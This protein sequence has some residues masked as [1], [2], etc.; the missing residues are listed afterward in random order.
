MAEF[1]PYKVLD[2]T[3]RATQADIK[4]AYRRLAKQYHPDLN[5]DDSSHLHERF[6]QVTRAYRVLGDP[7]LKLRFDR[8][9]LEGPALDAALRADPVE[10]AAA[11]APRPAAAPE[12]PDAAAP[13]RPSYKPQVVKPPREEAPPAPQEKPKAAE[14]RPSE[15]SAATPASAPAPTPTSAAAPRPR[16]A[17]L[18]MPLSFID[19]ARGT[20]RR[21]VLPDGSSAEVT[22]PPGARSGLRLRL[23]GRGPVDPASGM[24]SDAVVDVQVEPHPLFQRDDLDILLQLPIALGEALFGATVQVPTVYGPMPLTIPPGSNAFDELAIP[25]AGIAD[26]ESGRR[27]DQ[28]VSLAVL[29]PDDAMEDLRARL[30]GMDLGDGAALREEAGLS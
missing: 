5:S 6:T 4:A 17:L 16:D 22:V 8:G 11:P 7:R 2:V 23:A 3:R 24:R 30:A 12:R 19:A 20:V 29:L 27:G 26:M 14:S 15:A 10:P 25:G 9:E 13:S 21:I 1:D 18:R 28:R